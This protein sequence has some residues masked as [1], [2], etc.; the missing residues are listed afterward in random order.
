MPAGED[1]AGHL[2]RDHR[3]RHPRGVRPP[4]RDR[5]EPRRR[6]ADAAH[7]RPAR[8]LHAQPAPVAQGPRR[9]VG[10]ARPVRRR[11]PRRRARARDRRVHAA[12]VLDDR[13]APR[14]GGRRAVR[15][16]ARPHRRRG[17]RRRRRR[18][19]PSATSRPSRDAPPGRHQ[20]R[21]P[22]PEALAGAA[23]HDLDPPAGGEPQA[24]ASARSGR[25][26]SRSTCT[27]ASR[28]PRATSGSSPTCG[29]TRP[30]WRA[31][32][33]ARP[34]RS[35]ATATAEP[36]RCP[37]AASTRP[38]P[39]AP[40]RPTS[41]SARPASAAT[42]I[43]SPATSSPRSCACTGSS[44][45]GRSPRRWR[46]KELETTTIDLADGPYE[47]RASA[48]KVLFDG[49]ARVYTEGR[50]DDGRRR[51]GDRP[52]AGPGRGRPRRAS[53]DVT[54]T[55]HFT[56]PPP[57]FTEATLIKALEEHGIGRPSTYAATISTIVD[58]GYVRVEERRLHPELVARSSPTC[59]SS[60]SATTST[61]R[62]RPGWRRSSTRSPAASAPGCR[63]C[64]RSTGRCAT[65]S[66]RSAASS[67][68]SDFTT[69]ATD[70]VC[71]EGH[72]MVIRLG[73]NGRF[74]ACSLYPRAQGEP[75]AAR[76][77]AAAPGGHRRGLPEVRRGD[78]RRQAR[79]VRAVRRLLA[80]PRLRLHQAGRPAAAR[81]AAVRGHLPQEPRRPPRAAS[82][83]ADRE[84]LLGMLELPEVRLHDQPRA[85][86]RAA[87]TPTTARSRAR[88]RRRSASIC[89]ST[90]DTAPDGIVPG[91]AVR[92]ADR[93]T[94][95]RSPDRRA[96]G[97]AARGPAA[98]P[99]R[100]TRRV[101]AGRSRRSRPRHGGTPTPRRT[102]RR[103]VS[104]VRRHDPA[105]P[106]GPRSVPPG[107][108]RT[109]RVAAHR[110]A[111]ATAVGAYLDWL[112]ER[113][114]DWRRPAGPTCARTR[115]SSATATPAHRSR[116]AWPRSARSTDGRPATAWPPAIRGARSPRPACPAGCPGPRDRPG[117]GAAGGHRRGPRRAARRTIPDARPSAL[118]LALRDRALVETAYAAGLRISELAA[119]DLGVA[120]SPARRAA[121]ASA[122][123]ARSGSACSG[124]RRAQPWRRTSSDG[125]PVLARRVSPTTETPPVEVF[126]NHHGGPLGVRGLRYRLDR[127]CA[128]AGLP[129]GVSPHTLRHSFATH[130][131]D[132]GADLRVV[133]ELLGPREP[134]DDP[135]LH[136]RLARAAPGGL[137][138]GAPAGASRTHARDATGAL[139]ARAGLIV[140]A[141]FLVS[142]VLGWVRSSSSANVRRRRPS[143]TRSS[144]RSGSRTCIF[145]LVAA[146][147][148]SSALIPIVSGLFATDERP[149]AWR[150]VSTVTNLMLIGAGRARDRH[151][152]LRAGPGAADHARLRAGPARQDHRADPDHAAEPDLPGAGAVA[153]SVLNAGGRFAASA[154][155]PIV[156]NLAII[157]AALLL[158]PT[159]G[160]DGL[161]HRRRGRLARPS[162]GPALAATASSA[163][164]TCPGS[165]S[166]TPRPAGRWR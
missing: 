103:R 164:A 48:T 44:G 5:P 49:F 149:R 98:R 23:V 4:P 3:A 131:L 14:D 145:Q 61:S 75:A 129:D 160:V 39:R 17:A 6:P 162:A 82:R 89:G 100:R 62:S 19:P 25:C 76:R 58:R 152:H 94:R 124:A 121:G 78:A 154:V 85:A 123:A 74:L 113:G 12:R 60:I 73:R 109:R 65:A 157:G 110:R 64:A 34:A 29:R 47:L 136:P 126:L 59:S 127:L 117:R 43:R 1:P 120:R 68:A 35:S 138:G 42:R 24:R 112:A 139:L 102:G 46:A 95:R 158:A 45:S 119:A 40:R 31:W 133:Q 106:F 71:S 26:R 88:A 166:A 108:R 163:S 66:T 125:R 90:S 128:R 57:R 54:P 41:R 87:T 155:A 130:L 148:L 140:S 114:V 84:R 8:R 105:T 153:T 104:A 69:E 51:R 143:S 134:G 33:W 11:P 159:L 144:P 91:R 141:A 32:P 20:G 21:R 142:R 107:P 56:E 28:R 83:A 81:P 72:P 86:R 36:T 111:Y 137:P 63:C 96:R 37:R 22:D 27:R 99:A 18:R 135:D 93:R 53:I 50:D 147:A 70:E 115:P 151:L 10:R 92:R 146:G 79:P 52:A 118:A 15:G 161:A 16:R 9:P 122:R 165:T 38:R 116:S 156:Y 101:A 2:Q 80:L 13:G 150:V 77:G 7:R 30:R 97:A 132:G 67:S 55:Q